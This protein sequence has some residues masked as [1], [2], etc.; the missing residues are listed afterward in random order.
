LLSLTLS[1]KKDLLDFKNSHTELE[2]EEE[3]DLRSEAAKKNAT[4]ASLQRL[5][6][7]ADQRKGF[8][9]PM[10]VTRGKGAAKKRKVVESDEEEEVMDVCGVTSNSA[11]PSLNYCTR[12]RVK[13]RALKSKK[14]KMTMKICSTGMRVT[15]CEA[16]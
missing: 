1:E 16:L 11:I 2:Y 5:T 7:E 10:P 14:M 8:E 4:Y 13:T 6:A 15:C 3:L 12:R 9:K